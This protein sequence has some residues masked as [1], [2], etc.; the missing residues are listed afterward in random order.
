MAALSLETDRAGE[1]EGG[2]AAPP[3][4][5]GEG[6]GGPGSGR[7]PAPPALTD[8]GAVALIEAPAAPQA[9]PVFR[10][11]HLAVHG[12]VDN[13]GGDP[14]VALSLPCR[15]PG[16]HP[17]AWPQAGPGRALGTSQHSTLGEQRKNILSLPPTQPHTHT[18]HHTCTPKHTHP[19]HRALSPDAP[20]EF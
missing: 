17:T 2:G 5:G 20:S 16:F 8:T 11:H 19:T 18:T 1:A 3:G 15:G 13:S 4:R 10:L 7:C 12:P 14:G 6:L 9:Q